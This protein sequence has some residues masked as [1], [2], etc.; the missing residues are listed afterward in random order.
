MVGDRNKIGF[1]RV[2]SVVIQE[3]K[4][5]SIGTKKAETGD[6]GEVSVCL[7]FESSIHFHGDQVA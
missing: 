1:A 6:Q 2:K 5:R 4:S 3:G 7:D